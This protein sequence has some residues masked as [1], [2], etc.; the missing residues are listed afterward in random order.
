MKLVHD[1]A[2]YADG[3]KVRLGDRVVAEARETHLVRIHH[4]GKPV[5]VVDMG[6]DTV[7]GVVLAANVDKEDGSLSLLIAGEGQHYLSYS[8]LDLHTFHRRATRREFFKLAGVSEDM[9]RDLWESQVGHSA[10][11]YDDL[12]NAWLD[13]PM[14]S[15]KGEML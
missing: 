2:R 6:Q 5:K 8:S 4:D 14:F 13:E 9:Q 10:C 12:F 7:T 15:D 3:R 1:E 11:A